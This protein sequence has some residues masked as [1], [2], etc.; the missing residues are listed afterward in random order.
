VDFALLV[1]RCYRL[2]PS[3]F[4]ARGVHLAVGQVCIKGPEGIFHHVAALIGLGDNPVCAVAVVRGDGDFCPSRGV[5]SAG[6][7]LNNPAM[8]VRILPG[9]DDAGFV[10]ALVRADGG[11]DRHHDALLVRSPFATRPVNVL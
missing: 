4:P 8:A 11:I 1:E 2:G 5:V 7:V 6:Q 3:E 10:T 9:D